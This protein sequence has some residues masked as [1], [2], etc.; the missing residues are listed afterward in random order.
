MNIRSLI[1]DF[2][3]Q[4]SSLVEQ[5]AID[6][7]RAVVES[8]LGGHGRRGTKLLSG[9]RRPK[10]L[11]PVPGCKNPAAPVFGMVC[12][13]H[14]DIS[15]AQIAKY[16]DARRAKKAKGTTKK[17]ATRTTRAGKAAA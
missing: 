8:A 1:E 10:Q 6:R 15:K 5:D 16:R 14:K 3:N 17:R 12:A 9:A 11:C 2:T 4:L 7:A 13:K